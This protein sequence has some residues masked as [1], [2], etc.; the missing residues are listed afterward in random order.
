MGALCTNGSRPIPWEVPLGR[1]LQIA[2]C[3]PGQ[4]DVRTAALAEDVGR[5]IARSGAI[6]ICGGLGGA[7]EAACRGAAE[8]GGL[9]IG[10][11]PSLNREDANPYV[12]AAVATGASH[13]RN[14]F[15]V[16]SADA[17]IAVGGEYGTL[18]EIA[19][20]LKLGKPVVGLDTWE[21][22]KGEQRAGIIQAHDPAQA[23]EV[24]LKAA[25]RGGPHS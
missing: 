23:V 15:I 21:C 17:V 1:P 20:A 6:L 4:C 3:G 8:A 11:L 2:V 24:A 14:F 19:L 13:A 5:L 12:S 9:S 25:R 22:R 16:A 7:M 10:I 18:S